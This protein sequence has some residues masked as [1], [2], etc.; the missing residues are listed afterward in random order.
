METLDLKKLK[1]AFNESKDSVR[2]LAILSP[3]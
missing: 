1:D 2:I 3:T